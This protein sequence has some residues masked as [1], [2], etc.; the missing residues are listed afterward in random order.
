MARFVLPLVCLALVLV[1][2]A[3]EAKP[4]IAMNRADLE[5]ALSFEVAPSSSGEPGGWHGGPAG[6]FFAD[7]K[8]VHG[9]RWSARIERHSDSPRDFTNIGNF[10]PIDFSGETVE[11][12][13]FLRTEDVSD[14]AGLWLRED[15]TTP[16]LALDNMQDQQL[17]GTTGWKEYSIKLHLLPEATRLFFGVLLVGTGKAWADDLQ[18]L[19]VVSQF[20]RR[21]KRSRGRPFLMLITSSTAAPGSAS[22]NLRRFRLRT[23]RLWAKSGDSSSTII[24]GS[25]PASDTGT[26][27]YSASYRGF[28]RRAITRRRM[29]LCRVGLRL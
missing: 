23:W 19:V 1:S 6:T 3:Q 17:K 10:I 20:G 14:F 9:G 24:P 13:G 12:R 15:G 4:G 7:D 8:V 16:N 29:L 27:S 11:L 26:M 25:R 22:L 18:L 28:S 2:H 21:R 5:A